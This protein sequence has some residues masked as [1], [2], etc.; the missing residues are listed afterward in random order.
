MQEVQ[1]KLKHRV[2]TCRLVAEL[3]LER[4]STES[5][6]I[7]PNYWTMQNLLTDCQM[8]M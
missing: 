6:Y 1:G 5:H 2:A 4:R 7:A 3:R 8:E